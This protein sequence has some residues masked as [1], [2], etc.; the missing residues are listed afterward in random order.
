MIE[1]GWHTRGSLGM[2]ASYVTNPT[3]PTSP[4]MSGT[5]TWGESQ[6]NSTPPHV[7]AMTQAV[8]L[9]M[10]NVCPLWNLVKT[11]GGYTQTLEERS[12]HPVKLDNFFTECTWWSLQVQKEECNDC[13]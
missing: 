12:S 3:R 9:P 11:L 6:S 5:K 2:K 10:T 1:N 8:V 13:R 7:R 4:I